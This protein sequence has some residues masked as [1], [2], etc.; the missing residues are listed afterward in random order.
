MN[1]TKFTVRVDVK[2]FEVAKQY[3]RKHGTTITDLVEAYFHSLMKVEQI[4]PETPIL[5]ELAGS[6]SPE[7]TPEDYHVYLE[8]KYFGKPRKDD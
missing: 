8:E 7:V 5:N 6:L 3:A 2:S 1:K 4:S